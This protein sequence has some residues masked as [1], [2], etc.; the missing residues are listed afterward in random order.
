MGS[1]N[2]R[3]TW[4]SVLENERDGISLT[5][6]PSANELLHNVVSR[7]GGNGIFIASDNVGNVVRENLTNRNAGDGIHVDGPANTLT[8]NS[9]NK[10]GDLGIEAVPGVIDGGGN[11]ASGN[12]NPLQCLNVAC[13]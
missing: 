11:H 12:G 1:R 9:A 13:S 2:N 3:I 5:L 6:F 4:N 10:N 7:N 8:R